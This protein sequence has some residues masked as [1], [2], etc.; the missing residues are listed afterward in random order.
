MPGTASSQVQ[1]RAHTKARPSANVRAASLVANTPVLFRLPTIPNVPTPALATAFTETAVDLPTARLAA[2]AIAAS[3]TPAAQSLPS[4]QVAEPV[5]APHVLSS[6]APKRTWWEHWSSGIVLIVLLIAL[7]TASILAW[8]GAEKGNSKLI[9][10]TNPSAVSLSDLSAI[11]VPKLDV[12][13]LIPPVAASPSTATIENRNASGLLDHSTSQVENSELDGSLIPS[14]PISLSFDNPATSSTGT[15]QTNSVALPE[16]HA[17]ASLQSPI[18]KPQEPLFKVDAPSSGSS[19]P[20]QPASTPTHHNSAEAGA[21]PS[22]WDS[23]KGS[24]KDSAHPLTLQL[25]GSGLT[26]SSASVP[27]TAANSQKLT[28]G[29]VQ[30]SVALPSAMNPSNASTGIPAMLVSQSYDA[31]TSS[32]D[33]A[34]QPTAATT[35]FAGKTSTPELDRAALFA[36]FR[37][38]TSSDIAA[39]TAETTANRYKAASPTNA[40]AVQAG[41]LPGTAASTV[42]Y[43]QQTGQPYSVGSSNYTLQSPPN[44]GSIPQYPAQ[45]Q[46]Q[47]P[48][49]YPAQQSQPLLPAP[50]PSYAPA[51]QPA[52]Q[53]PNGV[54]SPYSAQQPAAGYGYPATQ[55]PQPNSQL[56]AQPGSAGFAPINTSKTG[57]ANTLGYPALN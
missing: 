35:Q 10:D 9:A 21:S 30:P 18:V 47:N 2:I 51:S 13:K 55:T 3:H 12:P 36:T 7:A 42:G 19:I 17:T 24:S 49:Q 52:T 23:S 56:N 33:A 28:S 25:G 45:Y 32:S 5:V 27:N 16:H 31:P 29:T 43:T 8:Q 44:T 39:S 41:N 26:A 37:Q 34:T 40:P 1:F 20:V 54:Q 53:Y 4:A 11:E 15:T 38:Y 57:T 48:S 46:A 22:V 6:G 50:Q 14:E